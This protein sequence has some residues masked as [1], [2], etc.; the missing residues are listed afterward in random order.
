MKKYQEAI[1]NLKIDQKR[2]STQMEIAK[3]S[4]SDVGYVIAFDNYTTCKTAI[5]CLEDLDRDDI[6]DN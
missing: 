2:F 5:D 1:L 4:E 6:Y 3:Q